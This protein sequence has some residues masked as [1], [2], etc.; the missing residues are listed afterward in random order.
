MTEWHARYGRPGVMIYWHVERKSL[1]IDSQLKTCSAAE[2]AAMIEGLLRHCGDAEIDRNYTDTHGASVIGFAVT[3]L[4]GF[5]LMPRLKNIGS[6][7]LYRPATG[8][9]DRWL[10]IGPILSN[11]AKHR[12]GRAGP[13][14]LHERW[15]QAPHLPGPR[16]TRASCA[17]HLHR[18][19]PGRPGDAH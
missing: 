1:C 12:R 13:P 16:G 10:E 17:D 18:R 19:I 8:M 2:V 11:K 15:P 3:H 5:K 9:D 7:R 6:A 4:L 14:S